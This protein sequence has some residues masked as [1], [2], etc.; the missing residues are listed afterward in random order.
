MQL[1][2]VFSRGDDLCAGIINDNLCIERR[3]GQKDLGRPEAAGRH[4]LP[5]TKQGGA[6]GAVLKILQQYQSLHFFLF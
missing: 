3:Q 5:Y 2:I 1:G 6:D 4:V